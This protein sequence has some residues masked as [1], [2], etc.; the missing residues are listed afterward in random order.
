MSSGKLQR[1]NGQ[2]ERFNRTLH[3]LLRTLPIA[4]KQ[5]WASCLLQVLFCYNTT[6]HQGTSESPFFLMFG[7]EPRLP[8]DFLL[9]QVQDPAAGGV[10]DWVA[11]HQAGLKVA[12]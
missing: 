2:C 10:R 9:G 8:V 12:F 3:N 7:R 5:D 4:Q 1:I 11:E 6:P